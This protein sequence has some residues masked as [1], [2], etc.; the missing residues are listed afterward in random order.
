MMIKSLNYK[1]AQ[2]LVPPIYDYIFKNN[3]HNDKL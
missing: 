3:S 2:F 1:N